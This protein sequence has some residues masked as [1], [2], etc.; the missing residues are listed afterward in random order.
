MSREIACAI[1][2]DQL[3]E[4]R[5]L[6]YAQLAKMI[7]RVSGD[8]ITGSDGEA[9]QIETEIRWDGAAGGNIRVMVA[10]DGPEVSSLKP[11]TGDF[12]ISPDGTFVGGT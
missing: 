11:L 2:D 7:G 10:V 8:G 12:I 3:K 6:P 5:K 1:I 9:Y 4:L